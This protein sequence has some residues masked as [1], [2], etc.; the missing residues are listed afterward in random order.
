MKRLIGLTCG[1]AGLCFGAAVADAAPQ[2]EPIIVLEPNPVTPGGRFTATLENF[3]ND[4]NDEF[5]IEFTIEGGG[6]PQWFATCAVGRATLT[7][8]STPGQYDVE[9]DLGR[10]SSPAVSSLVVQT[11][12]PGPAEPLPDT[13]PDSTVALAGLGGGLLVAGSVL[14]ATGRTRRPSVR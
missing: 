1:V 11:G 6:G 13:G 3:C 8:P 14:F 2:P 10:F 12:A 5:L 7:A 9:A 4:D